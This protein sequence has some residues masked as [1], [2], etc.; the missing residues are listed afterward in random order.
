MI[1]HC[2][3]QLR[4]L[5]RPV[6]LTDL[7]PMMIL[8]CW[9]QLHLLER[10]VG[11]LGVAAA[12]TTRMQKC[13]APRAPARRRRRRRRRIRRARSRPGRTAARPRHCCGPLLRARSS[14]GHSPG[15]AFRAERRWSSTSRQ[16]TSA[17]WTAV[18]LQRRLLR[19]WLL[20]GT[21]AAPLPSFRRPAPRRLWRLSRPQRSCRGLRA[22]RSPAARAA[23][24][25]AAAREP[26]P[27]WTM[28]CP[29]PNSWLPVVGGRPWCV[30]QG[31]QRRLVPWRLLRARPRSAPRALPFGG[32][33]CARS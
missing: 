27:T 21:P 33:G 32:G 23:A 17:L 20:Q 25:A 10:P 24:T 15:A 30:G 8:H 18:Q 4:L 26:M 29:S 28:R 5:E 22:R 2:L 12:P 1:L 14:S 31:P 13:Q 6:L 9:H 7:R 16:L 11:G 19:T 3:L